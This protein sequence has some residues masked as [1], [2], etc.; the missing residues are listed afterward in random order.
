MSAQ[1]T[2]HIRIRG[3][4]LGPFRREQVLKMIE[5][6]Q[7]TRRHEVSCDGSDWQPAGEFAELFPPEAAPAETQARAV[8]LDVLLQAADAMPAQLGPEVVWYYERDGNQNGPVPASQLA[9]LIANG[10]VG[11]DNRVWR[12]GMGDWQPVYATELA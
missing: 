5:R 7:L 8:T 9:Q 2:Y 12:D 3:N 1:G 11:P 4:V 6:G 10:V